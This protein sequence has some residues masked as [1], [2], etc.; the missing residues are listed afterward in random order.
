MSTGSRS[1]LTGWPEAVADDE[2]GLIVDGTVGGVLAGNPLRVDQGQRA[3]LDGDG[4]GGVEDFAGGVGEVDREGN[5]GGG[6][7]GSLGDDR[8]GRSCGD[9]EGGRGKEAEERHLVLLRL[10]SYVLRIDYV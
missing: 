8:G 9:K 1:H 6:R 10:K 3:G 2:A 5:G 4:L 7:G